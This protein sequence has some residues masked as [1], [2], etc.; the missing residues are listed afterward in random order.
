MIS[1]TEFVRGG[2]RRARS[3][4]TGQAQAKNLSDRLYAGEEKKK[5]SALPPKKTTMFGLADLLGPRR[6]TNQTLGGGSSSIRGA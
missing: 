6:S 4:K 1:G 3:S 2:W 5:P